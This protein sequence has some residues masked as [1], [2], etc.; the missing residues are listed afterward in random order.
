VQLAKAL[1]EAGHPFLV[2]ERSPTKAEEAR[3]HGFLTLVGE[4]THEE[5]LKEAGIARARVL[6][7]VLP[8]D[9]ANVFITLSRAASTRRYRSSRA[10]KR[11]PPKASCSTPGPTKWC[12]PPTSAPNASPK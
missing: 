7:T 1:A 10:A 11:P 12:C 4:A 9:A 2:L 8:D 3:S 6:A 5:T